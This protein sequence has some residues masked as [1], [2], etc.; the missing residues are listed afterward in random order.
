MCFRY[1]CVETQNRSIVPGQVPATSM[2]FHFACM[3]R[4]LFVEIARKVLIVPQEHVMAMTDVD[5]A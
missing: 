4:H 3:L 1:L 5:E 2:W